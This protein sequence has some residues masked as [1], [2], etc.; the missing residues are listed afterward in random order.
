[1]RFELYRD[2]KGEW[3]W[4]LRAR[5]GEVIAESGEGYIRREDCEHGIALVRQSAEARIEDMT[6]KIA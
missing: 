3:R 1:M 5:N 2:A 6:T 4:R